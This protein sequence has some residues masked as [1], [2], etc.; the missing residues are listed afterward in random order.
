MTKGKRKAARKV[1]LPIGCA[2][3]YAK[4]MEIGQELAETFFN[5][6]RMDFLEGLDELPP[7]VAYAVLA[8]IQG[9]ALRDGAVS[10]A[11]FLTEVA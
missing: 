4:I 5:G 6:N 1:I 9:H 8:Q 3:R 2:D 7:R 11:T 10:I